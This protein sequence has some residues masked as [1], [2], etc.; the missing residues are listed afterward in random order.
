[1]R[2][3]RREKLG[4]LLARLLSASIGAW[5]RGQEPP[6]R[7]KPPAQEPR[8]RQDGR[9]YIFQPRKHNHK[10]PRPKLQHGF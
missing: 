9:P 1:M 6:R 2:W 8:P 3:R 7:L 4:V 10:R 5:P